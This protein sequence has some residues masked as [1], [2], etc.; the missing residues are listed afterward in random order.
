MGEI[1]DLRDEVARLK[2]EKLEDR[3]KL[4]RVA[5]RVAKENSMCD[6]VDAALIEAGYLEQGVD[7]TLT[8]TLQLEF[9]ITVSES[10]N[11][12]PVDEQVAALNDVGVV[13]SAAPVLSGLTEANVE[14]IAY[15]E[16]KRAESFFSRMSYCQVLEVQDGKP[17]VVNQL[18]RGAT[19]N[20]DYSG[21]GMIP[22]YR[23]TFAGVWIRD[24]FIAAFQSDSGQKRHLFS[25]RPYI[26]AIIRRATEAYGYRGYSV[27]SLCGR[28]S[29]TAVHATSRRRDTSE[30]CGGCVDVVVA[31]GRS[32]FVPERNDAFVP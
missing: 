3:K 18:P 19:N 8:M 16:E 5:Q 11:D 26:E 10:F 1:E 27:N 31:Q 14:S 29:A 7:M 23:E 13:F 24:P 4:V 2:R 6:T 25:A 28:Y 9:G 15:G 17:A 22:A 20:Q 30:I 32:E 12:L 21:L